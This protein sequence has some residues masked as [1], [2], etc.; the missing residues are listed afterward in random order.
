MMIF[1][2]SFRE[3]ELDWKIDDFNKKIYYI[4]PMVKCF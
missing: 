2:L 3:S 1:I 4:S